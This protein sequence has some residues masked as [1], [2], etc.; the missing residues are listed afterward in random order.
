MTTPK[1]NKRKFMGVRVG[2][3]SNFGDLVVIGL[4]TI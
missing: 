1:R 2:F 3:D 4:L